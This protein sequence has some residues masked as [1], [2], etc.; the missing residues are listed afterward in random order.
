MYA[1]MNTIESL[2]QLKLKRILKH[3]DTSCEPLEHQSKALATAG[4]YSR[5]REKRR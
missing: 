4:C 1:H 5:Y 3:V 2:N